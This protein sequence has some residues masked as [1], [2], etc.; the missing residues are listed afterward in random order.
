VVLALGKRVGGEGHEVQHWINT[1]EGK[2]ISFTY[3]KHCGGDGQLLQRW[4]SLVAVTRQYFR[5]GETWP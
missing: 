4:Q 3:G 5:T 1:V 2:A